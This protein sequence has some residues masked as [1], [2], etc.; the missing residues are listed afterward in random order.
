M[1]NETTNDWKTESDPD[2][3]QCYDSSA[4]SDALCIGP[5]KWCKIVGK[6]VFES[7]RDFEA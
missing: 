6:E 4:A 3:S 5:G 1:T 2:A 7:I